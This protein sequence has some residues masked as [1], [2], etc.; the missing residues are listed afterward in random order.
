[1]RTDLAYPCEARVRYASC[2]FAPGKVTAGCGRPTARRITIMVPQILLLSILVF[3]LA[4]AMPG[5]ALTGLL[6]PSIDPAALESSEGEAW[7]Q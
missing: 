3:L 2:G 1:M 4:K 6:D 7:P 5:D